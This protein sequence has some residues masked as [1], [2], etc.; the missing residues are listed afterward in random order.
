MALFTK[1][2]THAIDLQVQWYELEQGEAYMRAGKYGTA[3]K[4]FGDMEKVT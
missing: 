1:H 4:K 3:L 2:D